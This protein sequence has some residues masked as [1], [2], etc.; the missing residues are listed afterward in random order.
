MSKYIKGLY[1]KTER[2]LN[3]NESLAAKAAAL[4]GTTEDDIASTVEGL[5]F[6]DYLA[7]GNAVDVEDVNAANRIL[8]I[9]GME[10][11]AGKPVVEAGGFFGG[12]GFNAKHIAQAN[13]EALAKRRAADA[14]QKKLD[15]QE[16]NRKYGKAAQ[17]KKSKEERA[18]LDVALL[19]KVENAISNSFPDGDPM[20]WFVGFLE[21]HNL[22]LSDVDRV[23]K[24][25]YGRTYD[26]YQIDMWDSF[27][28][29]SEHDANMMIS[30][31]QDPGSSPFW[32]WDGKSPKVELEPNPWGSYP[33]S[34]WH[35]KGVNEADNPYV[36]P[37]SAGLPSKNLNKGQATQDKGEEL[38]RSKD[39]D[40]LM[41]GDEIEVADIDGQ[42]SPA[43]VIM[44][45]GPGNTVA[46]RGKGGVDVMVKK[47]SIIG[48]P[49]IN[50]GYKLV[51][52]DIVDRSR[53][54]GGADPTWITRWELRSGGEH[55]EVEEIFGDWYITDQ[56]IGGRSGAL[57]SSQANQYLMDYG[58]PSIDHIGEFL[59]S[60][61][62]YGDAENGP[63]ARDLEE[64]YPPGY[65]KG[66]W[67]TMRDIKKKDFE[68]SRE[69]IYSGENTLFGKTVYN[70]QQ[71][72][73]TDKFR[74][75]RE[76]EKEYH[77]EAYKLAYERYLKWKAAQQAPVNESDDEKFE[78][79]KQYDYHT[80]QYER[81]VKSQGWHGGVS[82]T[83]VYNRDWKK[84]AAQHKREAAKY[85]K[86]AGITESI[87]N[88]GKTCSKCKKGTYEETS[89]HDDWDGV[90]HCNKC[91]HEVKRHIT[92][93]ASGGATGA[94]AIATAPA[95]TGGVQKRNPP[96]YGKPEPKQKK[97]KEDGIGRSRKQ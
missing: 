21:K 46:V 72:F 60:H 74:G 91:N 16:W 39:V 26:Q 19:N 54:G 36:T 65:Q 58:A 87:D 76:Y 67:D 77:P 52:W 59:D 24:K 56:K 32:S 70:S 37:P 4:L 96:I 1:N 49:K 81:L 15:K 88:Q 41:F 50:E 61:R 12:G 43:K 30:Q 94:G 82:G 14:L 84:E 11:S 48:T 92:E 79:Q 57:T 8:G 2:V 55:L 83:E 33:G 95:S 6:S 20:D 35:K 34:R 62:M 51:G 27:A 45:K 68:R 85:K 80:R 53:L 9:D 47:D 5:T 18:A 28:A 25:Q 13:K 63:S 66:I 17:R 93:T 89:I 78:A 75:Q 7:L 29:D 31:G 10:E 71:F 40:D 90:L 38:A 69:K 3:E 97:K 23:M 73:D 42:P 64:A 86:L 22:D 44:P